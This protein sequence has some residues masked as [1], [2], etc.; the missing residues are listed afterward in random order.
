MFS[1]WAKI[2][3]FRG[4]RGNSSEGLGVMIGQIVEEFGGMSR[5]DGLWMTFN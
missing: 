5:R 4:G 2:S 3:E 1:D